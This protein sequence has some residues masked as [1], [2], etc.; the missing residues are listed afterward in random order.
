MCKIERALFTATVTDRSQL[1]RGIFIEKQCYTWNFYCF[2]CNWYSVLN[3]IK[4]K[5]LYNL[6]VFHSLYKYK[7][8]NYLPNTQHGLPPSFT[9]ATT[10]HIIRFLRFRLCFAKPSAHRSLQGYVPRWFRH[11]LLIFNLREAQVKNKPQM[12]HLFA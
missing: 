8:K 5:L 12:P 3:F 6:V 4:F 1:M 11:L 2:F 10:S 7:F 9:S